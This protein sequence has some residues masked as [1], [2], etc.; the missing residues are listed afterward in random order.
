MRPVTVPNPSTVLSDDN[1]AFFILADKVTGVFKLT[2]F[3]SPTDNWISKVANGF[4]IFVDRGI[5]RVIIDLTDN[6]GGSICGGRALVQ[7][8]FP[9]ANSN[10]LDIRLSATNEFLINIA[11]RADV[12]GLLNDVGNVFSLSGVEPFDPTIRSANDPYIITEEPNINMIQRGGVSEPYT[13]PFTL[14]CNDLFAAHKP[15]KHPWR[16]QDVVGLSEGFCGSTCSVSARSLQQLGVRFYVFGG[17][18]GARPFQA[19][20]FEGGMVLSNSAILENVKQLVSLNTQNGY[21]VTL[22][23]GAYLPSDFVYPVEFGS[24]LFY[25]GY[26]THGDDVSTPD[27]YIFLPSF[28]NVVVKDP[29]N[30]LSIHEKLAKV[31]VTGARNIGGERQRP[32]VASGRKPLDWMAYFVEK[33]EE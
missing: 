12:D 20:S 21:N 8:L 7:F 25:E 19:T 5:K 3:P 18:R 6:G 26:S 27:E 11:R 2:D 22:K 10:R 31:M 30:L 9:K 24:M 14:I 28:G 16:V 1:M 4:N 29:E 33:E 17:F 32:A 13:S 15:F 23:Q